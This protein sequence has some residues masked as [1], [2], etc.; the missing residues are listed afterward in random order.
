MNSNQYYTMDMTNPVSPSWQPQAS[1][2]NKILQDG[3]ITSNWKY[4]Q[5][6]QHN[7]NQIMKYNT[8]EAVNASGNNP[9]YGTDLSQ[10]TANVPQLYNSLQTPSVTPDSDLKRDFLN[11][12]RMSARMI[13][14]SIPTD[15]F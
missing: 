2:N 5:Y 4:R 9:Y 15:K 14:P 3:N 13:S 6:I 8:M 10:S 1:V 11:K 7:A 12:Q